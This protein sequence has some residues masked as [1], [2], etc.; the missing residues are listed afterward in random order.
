MA[1]QC[2]IHGKPR[3][4]TT[5]KSDGENERNVLL[6]TLL[7]LKV[8]TSAFSKFHMKKQLQKERQLFWFLRVVGLTVLVSF[9]FL[10]KMSHLSQAGFQ[11]LVLKKIFS[12]APPAPP[13]VQWDYGC[14]PVCPFNEVLE[15]GTQGFRSCISYGMISLFLYYGWP[16][17]PGADK[18]CLN[19]F[20]SSPKTSSMFLVWFISIIL[21]AG[22][23]GF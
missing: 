17:V 1:N 13:Q 8:Y 10:R 3:S 7:P 11:F 21:A 15:N 6:T 9:L 5:D 16:L 23:L 22:G 19:C 2:P 20:V 12:F 14:V 4:S 18:L